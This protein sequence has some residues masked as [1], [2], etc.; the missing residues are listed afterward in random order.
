M[1]IFTWNQLNEL[2]DFVSQF[3]TSNNKKSALTI[4][5]FD[6][7]HLG[8]KKLFDEV[9]KQNNCAK[10]IVTFRFTKE[11]V[12][13]KK[14][15]SGSLTTFRLKMESFEK[16]GFD[17]CLVIDFSV[18]FSRIKG[19][20]FLKMLRESCSMQFLA[21]GSDFH[22]GYNLDTG[23][24]ELSDYAKQTGLELSICEQVLTENYRISSSFLRNLVYEGNFSKV[25]ELLVFPFAFASRYFPNVINVSIIPADSK[26]K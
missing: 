20:D 12:K 26:Y 17:F 25:N 24:A 22:C 13:F 19:I 2:S 11:F 5:G 8:H 15:F 9:L 18:E 3:C 16:L 10:G 4:G 7:P 23:V 14:N 21:V 6:G 1:K